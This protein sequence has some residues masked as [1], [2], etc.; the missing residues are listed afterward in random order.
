MLN[1][2]KQATGT[3]NL[4]LHMPPSAIPVL[5]TCAVTAGKQASVTKKI[6]KTLAAYKLIWHKTL[7]G[8][9]LV[10]I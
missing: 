10:G 3:N 6:R 2:T 7:T 1:R 8:F 4:V 5:T 9:I